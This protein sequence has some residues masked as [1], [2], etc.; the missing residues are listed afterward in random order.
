[1]RPKLAFRCWPLPYLKLTKP[2]NK[3]LAWLNRLVA[4]SV[5]V[6][7]A[8]KVSEGKLLLLAIA[9][10][11]SDSWSVAEELD[12][13]AYAWGLSIV[14]VSTVAASILVISIRSSG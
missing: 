8:L 10:L 14:I 5:L 13:V 6:A 4:V 3:A 1:M 7:G 2:F 11:P 12:S 9:L